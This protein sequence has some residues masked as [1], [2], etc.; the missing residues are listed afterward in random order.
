MAD[1]SNDSGAL[2]DKALALDAWLNLGGK[3]AGVGALFFLLV[4]PSLI[5]LYNRFLFK[6]VKFNIMGNDF[7]LV[8][9]AT[10]GKGVEIVEGRL[11]VSGIFVDT[12]YDT[13][14]QQTA[15]IKQLTDKNSELTNNLQAANSILAETK[16]R[17][18]AANGRLATGAT[19]LPDSHPASAA[20][21]ATRINNLGADIDSQVNA[22]QK[23]TEQATQVL[24]QNTPVA[25]AGFGI[26]FGGF[27]TAEA[28]MEAVKQSGSIKSYVN[29]TILYHRQ[30]MWRPV[31]YFGTR[32][33][34]NIEMPDFT[35]TFAGAYVVDITSWCP[36]PSRIAVEKAG[37]A[38]QKD[39]NF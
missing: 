18:D 19:G 9:V 3:A 10:S 17:L 20:A 8:D 4:A 11:K 28:A 39:C 13:F 23:L 36:A 16:S 15:T 21:L 24:R 7:E 34:A 25:A 26:V 6:S 2:K 38:E 37:M 14:T 31:A 1:P 22:S 32:T 5:P 30:G 27:A 35:N 29:P 12:V 33:A